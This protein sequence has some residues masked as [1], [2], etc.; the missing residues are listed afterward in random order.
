MPA[1]DGTLSPWLPLGPQWRIATI[2]ILEDKSNLRLS[3]M[4][5]WCVVQHDLEEYLK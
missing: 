1:Q 2:P 4:Y 5:D 3:Q